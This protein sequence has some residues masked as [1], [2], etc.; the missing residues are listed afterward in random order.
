[1]CV[2]VE[3]EWGWGGGGGRDGRRGGQGEG[4][5]HP[6]LYQDIGIKPPKLGGQGMY[7]C[8]GGGLAA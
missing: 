1:M 6:E 8:G 5:L 2:H 7:V 3:G 4:S